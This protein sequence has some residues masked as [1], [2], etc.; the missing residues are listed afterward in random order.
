MG[1]FTSRQGVTDGLMLQSTDEC[2]VWDRDVVYAMSETTSICLA[3]PVRPMDSR[4]AG[5]AFRTLNAS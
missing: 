5:L 2:R 3:S 4:A 1:A